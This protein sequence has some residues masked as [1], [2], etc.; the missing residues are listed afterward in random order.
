M[1][2][3]PWHQGT[4]VAVCIICI[5]PVFECFEN[6][7][8]TLFLIDPCCFFFQIV[9]DMTIEDAA[10]EE[11]DL[12]VCPGGMPGKSCKHNKNAKDCNYA[13]VPHNRLF[14]SGMRS[15]VQEPST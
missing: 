6:A 14:D 4:C 10:K 9:A 5:E 15:L 11:F 13:Y 8:L 3:E 1:Q 2:D 7:Y 12:V